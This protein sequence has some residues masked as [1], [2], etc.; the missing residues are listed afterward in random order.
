MIETLS[1]FTLLAPE[2]LILCAGAIFIAAVVRGF[3]G[4]ALSALIM[5]SL[6]VIIPPVDLIPVCFM[7]EAT[8]SLL[9]FR[10]GLRDADMRIV[11]GLVI[12]SAVGLPIGLSL[13][14]TVPVE[15]SKLI[16]LV[17]LILLAAM[18]LLRIRLRFLATTPGLYS[19]GLTA[20]IATGLA[21]IGGMVVALYVL[22]Q[23]RS[24]RNM[25]GSLV[26]Y[27]FLGMFTST[28]YL[29]L[30]GVLTSVS[31][32]RALVFA[33]FVIAGVLI[34]SWLFRPSLEGFYKRFCLLLLLGLSLI[35]LLRV[36]ARPIR[37]DS[38]Y[39]V[40]RT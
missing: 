15:T 32:Q 35:S 27:L 12:G 33:P 23:E 14:T 38:M 30:F 28:I 16:A 17:L 34:G 2:H 10:G 20:G 19:S 22:S 36:C 18:Q 21:S 5:A 11:W 4:F 8:A 26:T 39:G 40:A 29:L 25:R 31:V 7:L 13:T 6:V 9:M 1:D 3:A 37:T 24:A